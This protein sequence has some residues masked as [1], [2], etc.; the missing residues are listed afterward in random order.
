MK[1]RFRYATKGSF[2]AVD[3]VSLSIKRGEL[4]AVIGESGSGKTTLAK[5]MAGLIQPTSGRVFFEGKPI[6][7]LDR[8]ERLNFSRKVQYIPQYPDLALDPSWYIYDSIAEPLRIHRM[9]SSREEE[10]KIVRSVSARFGLS[11]DQ[12]RRKPRDVSGGE[13]QRA[14]LARSMAL[15]PEVLIADEPTSMLDP[16][17]QARIVRL[18]LDAQRELGFA[19][20]FVTHDLQLARVISDSV[21]VMLGGKIIE[22]G[23]AQEIFSSPLHPY[24]SSLFSGSTF[25]GETKDNAACPFYSQCNLRA[26]ICC[27]STPPEFNIGR[28]RGVRCWNLGQPH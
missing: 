6:T 25:A 21:C 18:I 19:V 13:L 16:S 15:N 14:V 11:L 26:E 22:F 4:L 27:N 12:L 5:I 20:L 23:S 2:L 8:R 3:G 10:L 7:S 9:S 1:K 17:T 28:F 24:T